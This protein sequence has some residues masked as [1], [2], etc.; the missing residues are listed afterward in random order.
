MACSGSMRRPERRTCSLADS[1]CRWRGRQGQ[2]DRNVGADAG[3]ALQ[4]QR[5]PVRG[6]DATADREAE[7][8]ASLPAGSG[9][10]NPIETLAD[11]RQVLRCDTD[12]GIEDRDA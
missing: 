4:E 5:A 9:V 11:I 8:T 1:A 2:F 12:P 3:L 6:R 7:T 10:R